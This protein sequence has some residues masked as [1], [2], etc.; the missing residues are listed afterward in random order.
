M[1]NEPLMAFFLIKN[2][3]QIKMIRNT[4]EGMSTIP[5]LRQIQFEGFYRF[6]NK[7]LPEEFDKFPKEEMKDINQ[8]MEFRLFGERY[9]LLEPLIKERDAVYQSL[10]YSSKLYVPA[11][12]IRKT[13]RHMQKQIVFIGNIPIM[14]SLG[15]FIINGIYRTVINQILQSPGIDYRSKL[16]HKG[17]SIYTGTL[18]SDW[19]GRSK[20][21]MD[22][23]ARIWARVSRKPKISI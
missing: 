20:L 4:N 22:R 6:I 17:I 14:S 1:N 15:T 23:K 21:E 18:I 5:G 8:N 3:L 13:S 10:T 12:L 16:D 11:G 7:G 9:Q 2:Q 19:G